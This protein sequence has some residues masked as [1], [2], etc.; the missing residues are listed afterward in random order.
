MRI[1]RLG[2]ILCASLGL[3]SCFGGSTGP[4]EGLLT[5]ELHSPNDDDGA[6]LFTLTGGPVE[7]IESQGNSVY[8]TVI[9]AA[10]IRVLIAGDLGSGALARVRIADRDQAAQ[11][12]GVV[13]QVAQ[14]SSYTQRDPAGYRLT[15]MR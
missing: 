4:A 10:T 14:R 12:A 15:V 7:A 1:A 6:V 9:D 3:L 5:L 2:L 8:Y 11:Y 13:E